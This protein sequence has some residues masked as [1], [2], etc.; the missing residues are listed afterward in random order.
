MNKDLKEISCSISVKLELYGNE[1]SYKIY[2]NED[3]TPYLIKTRRH[4]LHSHI[5]IISH[6]KIFFKF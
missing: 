5:I 1:I 4:A 2:E 6:H 3:K